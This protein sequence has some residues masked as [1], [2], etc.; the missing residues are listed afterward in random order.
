MYAQVRFS[1]V[2]P[3]EVTGALKATGS[4]D[5]DILAAAKDQIAAPYRPLKWF[6]IWGIVTGTLC[7]LLVIL[8]FIG[9]PIIIF[10][11][12]A[13]R[14]SKKNRETIEKAYAEYVGKVTGQPPLVPGDLRAVGLVL[15][16][17]MGGAGA[18]SAQ[19]PAEFHGDWVSARATCDAAVRFRV[20][21][22]KFTLI[23]G[24]DT[25]SFGGIE[26]AGPSYF[27]PEYN[28]IQAV[29]ISEFEGD[30]PVTATFNFN[31]KKGTAQ[32]DYTVLTGNVQ[33]AYAAQ[34]QRLNKL[35]LGKRFP[36]SGMA[37]KKCG[38]KGGQGATGAAGTKQ[39]S[40]ASVCA[41]KSGCSE[42]PQMAM[43]I[44]DFRITTS[45]ASRYA[46][47]TLRVTN[48]S[49]DPLT[50]GY[51]SGSGLVT[52]DRG[53]R[54][55][56][57]G[58]ARGMGEVNN[59]TFDPKF[60]LQPGESRDARFE[61]AWGQRQNQVFGT[62]FALDLT[63]RDILPIG[64]SQYQLGQERTWRFSG[65]RDMGEGAV[66]SA[67]AAPAGKPAAGGNQQ[68]RPAADPCGVDARCYFAGPFAA[69][70][71]QVTSSKGG[72][73]YQF[74]KL[75]VKFTNLSNEPLILCYASRSAAGSD[76]RGNRFG[77][78]EPAG[79]RGIG[80]CSGGT[81][82]PQFALQPNQ[83]REASFEYQ[84]G[85]YGN[86]VL[87]TVW[88]AGFT[89][90]ELELLAGNQVRSKN[91]YLVSFKDLTAGA[92][93]GAAA[94]PPVQVASAGGGSGATPAGGSDG[95]A[96]GDKKWCDD[97]GIFTA[98]V[99]SVTPSKASGYQF[100]TLNIKVTNLLQEP[101]V[102]CYLNGT[103]LGTDER[104]NRYGT[105]ND[106]VRGIGICAGNS[107]NPQFQLRPG[108]SRDWTID[109]YTGIYRNT[110]LGVE[111]K[112]DFTLQRLQLI[113]G[114]QVQT[115]GDYAVSFENLTAGGGGNGASSASKGILGEINKAL[116]KGK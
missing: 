76:D 52:D 103:A 18:A 116:K 7:C 64:A 4:T 65:L 104:G 32:I 77:V 25:Q 28:G 92:A 100:V 26:M 105:R 12:W 80:T 46:A 55:T 6:G 36:I 60:T 95:T 57:S 9:V 84:T 91:E 17:L 73:G 13:L 112:A 93:G 68:I 3:Q 90:T 97:A 106:K 58:P 40:G 15:L 69:Y 21:A 108:E 1:L 27:G 98:Q 79:V 89:A 87:G 14:R 61:F 49:P 83:S 63:T 66:A 70:V 50:I 86:T 24:K 19:V 114:N 38:A 23:N 99:K 71:T 10:G 29:A 45:G 85:I 39:A 94:G 34:A 107:L 48:R 5:P 2:T 101:L 53:N 41:G 115:N 67:P 54:Y 113:P 22:A 44:E 47:V 75:N 62:Q 110:V 74:V 111:W 11:I 72:G 88:T 30:Q 33:P 20:E 51:V 42:I 82:D 31:E 96:C 81:A 102:L 43:A 16:T 78:R 109:Y 56:L 59:S 35:A 37:L 8:A